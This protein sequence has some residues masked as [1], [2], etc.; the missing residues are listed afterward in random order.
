MTLITEAVATPAAAAPGRVQVS[1][2][3]WA[4]A[5]RKL[6][7]DKAAMTAAKERIGMLVAA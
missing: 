1:R 4:T 6:G 7:Q 2:G 5:F 3:P